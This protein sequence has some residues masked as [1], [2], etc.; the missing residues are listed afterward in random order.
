[1]PRAYRD[2][3]SS[4]AP[5]RERLACTEEALAARCELAW[6]LLVLACASAAAG[7][8]EPTFGPFWD[9]AAVIATGAAALAGSVVLG[10]RRERDGALDV[11]LIVGPTAS[12]DG[13]TAARARRITSPR[14]RARLAARIEA[15]VVR[16][17]RVPRSECFQT[18]LVR[19][20]AARLRAMAAMLH[21]DE[22]PVS[23]IARINRLL[24]DPTSPLVARDADVQRFAV[25]VR[26]I[27]IDLAGPDRPVLSAVARN[28]KG[29]MPAGVS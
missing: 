19:T 14:A 29:L 6:V 17:E 15:L 28:G 24:E 1:M 27:E 20:H 23:A 22:V 8:L 7:R 2:P 26:Q 4:T 13:A 10:A 5:T 21:R 25:W 3:V 9:W 12:A 11:I 18:G 16:A